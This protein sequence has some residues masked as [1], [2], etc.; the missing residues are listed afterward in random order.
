MS[1]DEEQEEERRLEEEQKAEHEEEERQK[2]RMRRLED[3]RE[4]AAK[5]RAAQ[6]SQAWA[7]EAGAGTGTGCGVSIHDL[8]A[9]VL[10][11]VLGYLAARDLLACM[12]SCRFLGSFIRTHDDPL[13]RH[14]CAA[15]FGTLEDAEM[16]RDIS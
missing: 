10:L 7:A 5:R 13:W 8:S 14:L 3:A 16:Y 6:L 15:S 12:A 1:R 4:H 11:G 2:K 9:D